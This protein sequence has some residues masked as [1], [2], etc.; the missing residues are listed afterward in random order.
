MHSADNWKAAEVQTGCIWQMGSVE[1]SAEPLKEPPKMSPPMP[2]LAINVDV[3]GGDGQ[4]YEYCRPSS[5]HTGGVNMAFVGQNAQFIKE[6]ISYFVFA[7]LMA[8]DNRSVRLPG[9][10]EYVDETFREYQFPNLWYD[11]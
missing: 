6:D 11:P 4:T 1:P 5:R 8:S 9:K 2:S 3:G 10:T 7:R